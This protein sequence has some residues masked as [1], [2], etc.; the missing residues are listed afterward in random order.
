MFPLEAI[1]SHRVAHELL[2]HWTECWE[3]MEEQKRVMRGLH[4]AQQAEFS[5]VA[6]NKTPL[7]GFPLL[8]ELL[9][10]AME[11]SYREKVL[12]KETLVDLSVESYLKN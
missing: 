2:A 12:P 7:V 3:G 4:Q 10:A 9:A 11:Q 8:V 6:G 5:L 1:Q